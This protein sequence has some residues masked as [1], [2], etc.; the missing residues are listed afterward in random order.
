[1]TLLEFL[2][3]AARAGIVSSYLTTIALR[4]LLRSGVA[5]AACLLRHEKL[6]TPPLSFHLFGL[7]LFFKGLQEKQKAQ[8]V[9]LDTGHQV[10]EEHIRFFLVFDQ[11]IALAVTA[12]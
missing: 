7:L 6:R 8:R 11:W 4:L 3:A 2:S 9:I 1:M 12:E 5:I 10:F